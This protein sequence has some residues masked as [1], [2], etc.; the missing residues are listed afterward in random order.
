MKIA[1]SFF[2]AAVLL[3]SCDS[4]QP[5]KRTYTEKDIEGYWATNNAIQGTQWLDTLSIADGSINRSFLR[6][7][8][9]ACGMKDTV[10]HVSGDTVLMRKFDRS[11]GVLEFIPEYTIVF[12]TKERIILKEL[13]SGLEITYYSLFEIP[14]SNAHVDLIHLEPPSGG[15]AMELRRDSLTYYRMPFSNDYHADTIDPYPHTALKTDT[16][17]FNRIDAMY[18]RLSPE[19]ILFARSKP[20]YSVHENGGWLEQVG[21]MYSLEMRGDR[22]WEMI[23]SAAYVSNPVIRAIYWEL[24]AA[25]NREAKGLRAR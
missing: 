1:L 22:G 16:A 10:Y 18:A 8:N 19:D 25:E 17:W 21:Y 2:L 13:S 24:A 11:K 6:F 15:T 3:F 23:G 5:E 12:A 7:Y 4:S 14:A 9:D 20:T